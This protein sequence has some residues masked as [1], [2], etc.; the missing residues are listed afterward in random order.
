[1]I[2]LLSEQRNVREMGGTMRLGNYNCRLK[3]H[4]K[5]YQAYG[6]EVIGE[7][8]RHRYEFN[9]EYQEAME[10]KGFILSGILQDGSLCEIAEIQDHPWMVGVQFHPEFKSKPT[11]PHP[12]FRDFVKAMIR[13]KETSRIA[14]G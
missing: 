14:H 9:N 3:P 1:V 13:Q 8:H 7:R 2:S 10:Q 5:A 6:K 12:L 4:T 11:D